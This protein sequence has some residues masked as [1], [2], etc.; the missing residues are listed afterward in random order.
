[1]FVFRLIDA[2]VLRFDRQAEI[3]DTF[4]KGTIDTIGRVEGPKPA[5]SFLHWREKRR[6]G[7]QR[8]LPDC[9]R[10]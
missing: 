4:V 10:T 2:K 6:S 1:L 5:G 3:D 7:G 9:R 8:I